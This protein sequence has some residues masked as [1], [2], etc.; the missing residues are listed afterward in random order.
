[1]I[2]IV[3]EFKLN[4]HLIGSENYADYQKNEKRRYESPL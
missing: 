3:R 1:M 2:N 4:S